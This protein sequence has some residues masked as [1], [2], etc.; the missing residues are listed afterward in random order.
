MLLEALPSATGTLLEDKSLLLLLI[1]RLNQLSHEDR[2]VSAVVYLC[3][4]VEGIA[5]KRHIP[6]REAEFQSTKGYWSDENQVFNMYSRS[7]ELLAPIAFFVPSA[8]SREAAAV[9]YKR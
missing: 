1:E 7:I 5:E 9:S 6:K 4:V 8:N 3:C 2:R